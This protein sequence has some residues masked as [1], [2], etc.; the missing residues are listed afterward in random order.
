MK[1]F[2]RFLT[3]CSIFL[4]ILELIFVKFLMYTIA[5]LTR[6]T[7]LGTIWTQFTSHS[8][9]I[10]QLVHRVSFSISVPKSARPFPWLRIPCSC[11]I[12][13]PSG[14]GTN[15][16]MRKRNATWSHLDSRLVGTE[17]PWKSQIRREN[18]GLTTNPQ[19]CKF[20]TFVKKIWYG[21]RIYFSRTFLIL[22]AFW[23]GLQLKYCV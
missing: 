14:G 20:N 22:R 15:E 6:L 17:A 8:D 11:Q 1:P 4:S 3:I 16:E 23:S 18:Q 21:F 19:W 12:D 2:D 5:S 7:F 10:C 13:A 9:E